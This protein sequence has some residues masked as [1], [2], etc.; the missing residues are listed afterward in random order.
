MELEG[1]FWIIAGT[2]VA[3]CLF[4]AVRDDRKH[5]REAGRR[6]SKKRD[7]VRADIFGPEIICITAVMYETDLFG[8]A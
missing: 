7:M 5:A 1:Y 2:L 3:A 6:E 8:E 4:M